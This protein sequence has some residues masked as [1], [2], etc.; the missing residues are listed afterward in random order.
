V[1][2]HILGHS[3]AV[4]SVQLGKVVA[5][6][7]TALLCVFMSGCLLWSASSFS[8]LCNETLVLIDCCRRLPVAGGY[9]FMKHAQ[10]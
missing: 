3:A 9:T 1:K 4:H 5:A 8:Q 6:D 7:G 10:G 2:P